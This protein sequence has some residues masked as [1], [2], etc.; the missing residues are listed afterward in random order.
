MLRRREPY[1]R[2]CSC[3]W[4]LRVTK[5]VRTQSCQQALLDTGRPASFIAMIRG[6]QMC[7]RVC[8]RV[9]HPRLTGHSRIEVFNMVRRISC[10]GRR[11]A[12]I[13]VETGTFPWGVIQPK[14][15]NGSMRLT[16]NSK[17]LNE[18]STNVYLLFHPF[19]RLTTCC[20]NLGGSSVFNAWNRFDERIFPV[21]STLLYYCA[22]N[23]IKGCAAKPQRGW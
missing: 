17:R 11:T 1:E 14:A 15:S 23:A 16:C 8:C 22:A 7:G 12:A 10:A 6:R 5:T 18:Q 13:I 3:F 2:G 20:L 19:G 21:C 9:V 4:E